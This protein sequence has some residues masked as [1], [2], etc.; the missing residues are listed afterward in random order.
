MAR[1]AIVIDNATWHNKLTDESTPP[2]R[3]WSKSTLQSWLTRRGVSFNAEYT[4]AELLEL[5]FQ[6]IPRKQYLTDLLAAEFAV[7]IVRLPIKHC[8][9]NPI[10]LCWSQLKQYV[11]RNNTSFRLTDI[12]TLCQEYIA[13]LDDCTS[14]IAHTRK[15]EDT[16]RQADN[17][18]ENIIDPQ[19][20]D[21]ES[22]DEE[23]FS[24]DSSDD[25]RN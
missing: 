5:A 3:A 7:E 2:K 25:D 9:L 13:A 18:V 1:I 12:S 20:I 22:D 19:I 14:F 16:F 24:M 6:N 11:R 8:V 17:Y 10:E 23:E 15:A 4:K 21:S